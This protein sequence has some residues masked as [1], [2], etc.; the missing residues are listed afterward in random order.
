MVPSP[1]SA[2]SISVPSPVVSVTA[3]TPSAPHGAAA[4]IE[5]VPDVELVGPASSP[6]FPPQPTTATSNPTQEG[7]DD[8]HIS[9]DI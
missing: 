7:A 2:A 9:P 6:P 8:P 4:V 1:T 5:V 3:C